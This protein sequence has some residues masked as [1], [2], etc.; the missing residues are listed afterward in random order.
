MV[1]FMARLR[2]YTC[3]A[4]SDY[5][6]ITHWYLQAPLQPVWDALM[7]PESWPT[8]WKGVRAVQL[9]ESGDAEGV[10]ACRRMTWRSALPYELTF[11]MRTI[12]IETY[13][14]IEGVADG[15]L[16]GRGTWTLAAD[17]AC[18]RVRYEWIVEATRS[19][20]RVLA[21]LAKPLF[22]WNHSVV[23]NWGQQGLASRLA[24]RDPSHPRAS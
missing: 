1:Y 19:W 11:N 18:T 9:L 4:A 15:E 2:V 21:P 24:A 6:L 17:A 22:E 20:M 16:R 5:Q 7:Q 3:M 12:R 13:R 10:G 23:M 14:L 8:W